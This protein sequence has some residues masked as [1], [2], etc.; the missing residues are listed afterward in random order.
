MKKLFTLLLFIGPMAFADS[1]ALL[2]YKINMGFFANFATKIVSVDSNGD[3]TVET[4]NSEGTKKETLAQLSKQTI[5]RIEAQI[6]KLNDKSP[7]VDDDQDRPFMRDA[8]SSIMLVSKDGAAVIIK[9]VEGG[10]EYNLQ[11]HVASS[12][13]EILSGF[14][15]LSR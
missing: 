12:L 15:S 11:Y 13:V 4:Q 9:K 3:V 1:T 7:L 2:Q 8:G 5:A 10:H 14:E 6:E